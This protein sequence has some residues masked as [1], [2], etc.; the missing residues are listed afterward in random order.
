VGQGRTRDR[1]DTVPVGLDIS[2]MA[3]SVNT[4]LYDVLG[5]GLGT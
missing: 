2:G 4:H 3:A 1:D 5:I